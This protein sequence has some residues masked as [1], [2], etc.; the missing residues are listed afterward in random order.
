MMEN[1][2]TTKFK[3]ETKYKWYEL[4]REEPNQVVGSVLFYL[5][6]KISISSFF[7]FIAGPGL[8]YY[9][10]F[11]IAAYI[12]SKLHQKMHCFFA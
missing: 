1:K 9:V 2:L 7:L 3:K 5:I 12:S 10:S 8:G 6:Y 11:P 4:L